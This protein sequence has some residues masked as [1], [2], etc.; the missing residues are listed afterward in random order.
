MFLFSA[1]GLILYL[2]LGGAAYLLYIQSASLNKS[3]Q[4]P[5]QG[6]AAEMEVG[7]LMEQLERQGWEISYNVPA[8][9]EWRYRFLPAIA[10]V[11]SLIT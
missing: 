2:G 1:I 5:Y 6:V 10:S 7:N 11:L 8:K 3:T 9:Q 4:W